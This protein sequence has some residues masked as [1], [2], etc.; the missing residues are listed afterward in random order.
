MDKIGEARI[1]VKGIETGSPGEPKQ[2]AISEPISRF[3]PIERRVNIAKSRVNCRE[4]DR[5]S[6]TLHAELLEFLEKAPGFVCPAEPA[7]NMT[8]VGD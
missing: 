2:V 6:M 8:Q 1:R 4:C 3:Q 5:W 7:I